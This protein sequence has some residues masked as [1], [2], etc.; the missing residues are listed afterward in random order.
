MCSKILFFLIVVLVPSGWVFGQQQ[1]ASKVLEN[2]VIE[3][4]ILGK[5]V[6]YTIYLPPG[7]DT[8]ERKYP[9]VYLLHGY[10]DSDIAWVQFGEIQAI[11]DKAIREQNITPMIIVTPDAGVTWYINDHEGKVRY[12]DMFVEEFI[13]MIESKYKARGTREFRGISGLSM[14]GYGA[15]IYA[16]KHPDLFAASAP[17]SAAFYTEETV[18]NHDQ[19][20]WDRVEAIMYGT[21][22][23]GKKRITEHWKANNPFHLLNT[24]PIDKIKSVQYYFDCGDDDFLYEG[25]DAMHS[26]LRKKAIP[27]EYRMRD[28]AHT[29]TY[30]RTGI[31]QALAFIS[32][33]FHR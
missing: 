16:L 4:K 24:L 31:P 25:N 30:W 27:H 15:F 13:P 10:T 20:R 33:S 29:W 9:I 12:E 17:L 7:Y 8:S 5:D 11:A 1:G 32:K 2:Q 26:L 28:G 3:S 18:V 22:L 6:N 14:G 21:G 19:E 23:K